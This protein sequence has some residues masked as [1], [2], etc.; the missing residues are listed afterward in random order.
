MKKP[1]Q[2]H[3]KHRGFA[4]IVTIL[5]MVLL[6][7]ITV[8]TLS[9]SVVTVR[10]GGHESAQNRA[11]ANAKMALMIAIGEL[12]KQ[13]GP[14]QR[15]T[16]NS[17]ILSTATVPNPNW[18]GVWDS[19]IAG[20]LS[21]APVGANYPDAASEHQTIGSLADPKMRPNYLQKSK[22]FRGWLLSLNP[23]DVTNIFTPMGPVLDGKDMPQTSD[24]AVRLVGKGSLG[25]PAPSTDHV[26]ARLIKVEPKSKQS[27][28]RGRY[29]WWVGDESQKA[30]IME[31]S[32]LKETSPTMAKR[33]FR[34]EAPA[35]MG[36]TS[37]TGLEKMKDDSQLAKVASKGTV[38]LVEG[39]TKQDASLRFHDITT[40][41]VGVLADVREGGLKRDLSTILE[42]NIDPSE[43]FN[44]SYVQE[45]E[46]ANSY[47]PAANSFIL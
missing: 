45:F 9:L 32:Y 43:V 37:I 13:V 29:A 6:A 34:Q 7:I 27:N 1:N 35:S 44:L 17:S 8:G 15:I 42:R 38:G 24:T 33:L 5:L 16:A 4:L 20:D 36:N 41:S 12:Q 21:K 14:D 22:H 28:Y 30:T 2:L 11:R 19:W 3:S 46:R 18:T 26:S 10:S 39:V 25:S 47:K 23:D 31:D 40:S